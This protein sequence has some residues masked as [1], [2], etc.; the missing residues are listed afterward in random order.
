MSAEK[1]LNQSDAELLKKL[2]SRLEKACCVF[3]INALCDINNNPKL[4]NQ[5][6]NDLAL[7]SKNGIDFQKLDITMYTTFCNGD[8]P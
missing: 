8:V 6:K 7:L 1:Q 4:V 3:I 5:V 2:K